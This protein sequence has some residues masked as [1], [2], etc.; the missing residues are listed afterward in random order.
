MLPKHFTQSSI[1]K[2]LI[3]H[4]FTLLLLLLPFF[5]FAQTWTGATSTNWH[6]GSNWNTGNVPTASTDVTINNVPNK[7]IIS[8]GT[9]ALAKS[10]VVN[11][12]ASLQN[13][14]HLYL[15]QL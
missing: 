8:S 1:A 7:P 6:V 10:I 4:S 3:Q 13:N 9:N 14:I 12:N 15:H 2:R 5:G 11:A